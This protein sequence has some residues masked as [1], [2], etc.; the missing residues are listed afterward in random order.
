MAPDITHA[1]RTAP[2]SYAAGVDRRDQALFLSAF[3]PEGTLW[4]PPRGPG[5]E[6]RVLRGHDQ[7]A[8]VVERIGRYDRTFHLLG[9]TVLESTGDGVARAETY[10]VAHHWLT[11]GDSVEDTVL[12]IRYEDTYRLCDDGRWRFTERRLHEDARETRRVSAPTEGAAAP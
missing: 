5:A 12:H 3:H 7:L 9:Q 6:P 10:C 8:Q 11:T 1:L 4:I 2:A